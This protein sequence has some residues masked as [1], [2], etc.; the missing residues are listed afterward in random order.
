MSQV[1]FKI[2]F[3]VPSD[4]LFAMI[5]KMLP[6][7]DF[8]VEEIVPSHPRIVPP[9][10]IAHK[11][12]RQAYKRES[13]GPNLK[14]GINMIVVNELEKE[15]KRALELQPKLVAAGFSPN[16]VNSRLESLRL[17]GVLE[18]IGDGRWKLKGAAD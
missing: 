17:A 12:R 16:S 5:A 7:E 2:G 9:I 10:R 15:P 18:R 11:P 13:P 8:S 4:T 6:I 14:K 1:K 3:T